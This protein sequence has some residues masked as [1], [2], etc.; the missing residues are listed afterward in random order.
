MTLPLDLP[1]Q[2]PIAQPR[3]QAMPDGVGRW[4]SLAPVPRKQCDACLQVV[5]KTWPDPPLHV[6]AARYQR[7]CDGTTQL[8]CSEHAAPLKDVDQI[9]RQ[10]AQDE[11]KTRKK[12]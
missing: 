2:Q 10:R 8:L 11:R 5:H 6:A 9:A 1:A 3:R 4:R 7:T 12:R